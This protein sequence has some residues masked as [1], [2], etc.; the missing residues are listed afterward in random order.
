MLARWL[1]AAGYA[2]ELAE[3]AKRA[4]EI[5]ANGG[6]ALAIVAPDRLG[7]AGAALARELG[8][9]V[10]QVIVLQ[11]QADETGTS[12]GPPVTGDDTISWPLT[13]SDVLARVKSAL[14]TVPNGEEPA[15]PRVLRFEGYTLDTDD[16][17]CIDAKGQ[18]LTLTRAEFSLLLAF[19][20]Q[21]G[22]VLSRDELSHAVAGRGV[23]PDDRSVD[24]L[25]SRLR[26]KIEP[27]PKAPRIIVTVPGEGYKFTAKALAAAPTPPTTAAPPFNVVPIPEAKQAVA[28]Q[29]TA[30]D[31]KVVASFPFH[32]RSIGA[33]RMSTAAA[34]VSIIGLL[35]VFWY[36]GFAIRGKLG[37]VGATQKFDAAAIPFVFDNV[38][39]QLSNYEFDPGAK[40]IA[41]SR[42]GWG[43]GSGAADDETAKN[44]A[45]ERCRERDK[46]GFC[47]I[48]AV[49]NNVVWSNSM[50]TLPLPADVRADG[51]GTSLM[52]QESLEAIWQTVWHVSPP[53]AI[54]R[55]IPGRNNKALAVAMTSAY[56]AAARPS[57]AEAIRIAIER[58]SDLARAPCLLL[59]V[60]GLLTVAMPQSY[61]IIGPFTLAGERLMSETDR[62]GIA[63]IY[64]EKDW[65]ALARGKSGHWYAVNGRETEAAAADEALKMCREAEQECAMHA[66]GNWR[67]GERLQLNR[68]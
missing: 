49:G 38:R 16:R 26:R 3:A 57:R 29:G 59:S 34:L 2:V 63:K 67:V 9:Q 28:Q 46:G 8:G 60:D 14:G 44:E 31:G 35:I 62:Q 32:R 4:R 22:R 51:S 61:R 68:G 54:T 7:P 11:G 20:R 13:E 36:P 25:T 17:T 1:M 50:L 58:C 12:G 24:V 42:E 23:E 10:E 40:A 66:I 19:G 18:E 15:G 48:Y 65:R 21:P 5:V 39:A 56:E 55:Y 47:R 43:F 30:Q 64:A 27:D 33:F 45:L 41:V 6:I 53:Q 37:P 52:T